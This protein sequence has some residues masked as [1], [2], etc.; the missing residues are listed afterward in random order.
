M[1]GPVKGWID[2]L[3][4]DPSKPSRTKQDLLYFSINSINS[5]NSTK[6]R[7]HSYMPPCDRPIICLSNVSLNSMTMVYI[8]CSGNNYAPYITLYIKTIYEPTFDMYIQKYVYILEN[9]T[10]KV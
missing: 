1:K 4:Y 3:G 7:I 5:W 2:E 6:Y 10:R 8:L 9:T